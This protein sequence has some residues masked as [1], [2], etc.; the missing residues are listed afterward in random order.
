M[1]MNRKLEHNDLIGVCCVLKNEIGK[2]LFIKN[3]K[4]GHGKHF[5]IK[6]FMQISLLI[7]QY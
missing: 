7:V 4:R 2:A 1:M 5:S 6:L 3:G